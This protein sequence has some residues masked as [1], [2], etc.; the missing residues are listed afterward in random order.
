MLT[1]EFFGFFLERGGGAQGKIYPMRQNIIMML[2]GKKIII[3]NKKYPLE[4]SGGEGRGEE[5]PFLGTQCL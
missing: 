5:F 3:K 4:L 2:V 1:N